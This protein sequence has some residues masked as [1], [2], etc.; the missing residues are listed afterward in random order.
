VQLTGN[1]KLLTYSVVHVAAPAFQ[2]FVPYVVGIVELTEGPKLPA[3]IKVDMKDLKVG[4]DL[5]VEFESS[6]PE[7]WPSWVRYGFVRAN[8]A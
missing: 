7:S 5:K 1:G 2:S 6:K 4:M 8:P 3:M